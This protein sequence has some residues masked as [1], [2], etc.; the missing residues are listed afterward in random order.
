MLTLVLPLTEAEGPSPLMPHTAEIIFGFVF[1]ILL[2]IAFAKLVVPR[3]E[4][5]YADRTQAIE[6]GMNAA[7]QAQAEAKAALD[8][9]NAQLGEARQE[10]AKIREDAREQ[11]ALIIAEMREQASTEADRIVTHARTQIDAERAQAVASLRREVG[12][13]ATTLAS[14]IVGESLEE[15]ARQRRTVERFL[16]DLESSESARQA[17]GTD[18]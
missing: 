17:V 6:G 8:K 15:E 16:A 14:R 18:G 10:A 1:L 9:Y 7:K 2:A 3:F 4:K 11:G 13:M 5:A 12:T